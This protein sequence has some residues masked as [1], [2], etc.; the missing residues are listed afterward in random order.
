MSRFVGAQRATMAYLGL[1]AALL[2]IASCGG[3][4]DGGPAGPPPGVP[5]LANLNAT[6]AGPCTLQGGLAGTR[7]NITVD[8]TDSDGNLQGGALQTT[9]VLLPSG[10]SI[11]LIFDL[12]SPGATISGTTAGTIQAAGCLRFGNQSQFRLSVAVVDAAGNSSNILTVTLDRP[13]GAPEVPRG[14]G[15]AAWGRAG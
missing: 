7:V 3:G 12:P 5:A 13:A 4:G 6:F 9:G 8:Y 11:D 2:V 14:G 10:N 15:G 1:V